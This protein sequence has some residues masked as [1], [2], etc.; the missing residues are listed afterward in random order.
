MATSVSTVP[1]H[2]NG[3]SVHVSFRIHQQLALGL[4]YRLGLISALVYDPT[5][6]N[7]I[8]MNDNTWSHSCSSDTGTDRCWNVTSNETLTSTDSRT[9]SCT[10]GIQSASNRYASKCDTPNGV[11]IR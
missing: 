6:A 5:F 9:C 3:S 11:C 2:R 1:L 4:V 8:S 7:V 10:Q